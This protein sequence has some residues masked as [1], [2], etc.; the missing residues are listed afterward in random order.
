MSTEPTPTEPKSGEKPQEIKVIVDNEQTKKLAEELAKAETAKKALEDQLAKNEADRKA[1]EEA[2]KK[3][4]EEV[5]DLKNKLGI[6][7]EKELD[8]KRKAVVEKANALLKDPERVK[9][10]E[11][12]LSNPTEIA[13]MEFTMNQLEKQISIGEAQFKQY[14]EDEKKKAEEAVAA[15]AKADEEA[16]KAAEEAAR[17][18]KPQPK[19]ETPAGSA[20]MNPAQMGT[21]QPTDLMH[22][23]FDS[24]AAMITYL[25]ETE[26]GPDKERA[27]EAKVALN[28]LIGKWATLVRQA[29][30]QQTVVP[31]E[32]A[33]KTTPSIKEMSLS[34]PARQEL[35]RRRQGQAP[36]QVEGTQ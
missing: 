7:A 27:A 18:G 35:E 5:E 13:A 14:Q 12:K 28:S 21:P 6:I 3:S 17:T 8:K 30:N 34:R 11:S 26:N 2:A 31:Q 32:E 22:M 16:K 19:T 24:Y 23:K 25:R 29:H 9:E 33:G 1:Q 15:K 20:P 10:I 4:A 36:Q